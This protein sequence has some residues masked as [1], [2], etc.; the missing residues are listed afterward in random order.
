MLLSLP[1]KLFSTRPAAGSEPGQH[2]WKAASA[3]SHISHAE[4]TILIENCMFWGIPLSNKALKQVFSLH[5]EW[6]SLL[7]GRRRNTLG[8]SLVNSQ[9]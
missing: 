8:I 9:R 4:D 3:V 1:A 2:H 7:C 6:G 5:E